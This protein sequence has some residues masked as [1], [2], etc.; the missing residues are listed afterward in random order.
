MTNVTLRIPEDQ[1]HKCAAPQ[2]NGE[3][4]AYDGR[5]GALLAGASN[6]GAWVQF[7]GERKYVGVPRDWLVEHHG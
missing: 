4:F 1:K 3:H 5:T 7:D 6:G 2:Y